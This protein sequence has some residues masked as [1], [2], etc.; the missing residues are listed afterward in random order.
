MTDI[1][2]GQVRGIGQKLH[3]L[4]GLPLMQRAFEAFAGYADWPGHIPSDLRKV[5][6]GIGRWTA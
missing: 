2:E 3:E 6:D 1:F 4:G 5:W